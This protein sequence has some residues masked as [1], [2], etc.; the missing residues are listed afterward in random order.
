[1][2][3]INVTIVFADGRALGLTLHHTGPADEA[4]MRDVVARKIR[5]TLAGGQPFG[6]GVPPFAAFVGNG[7]LLRSYRVHPDR[8]Y[9]LELAWVVTR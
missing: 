7:S 9:D 6:L 5:G 2:N 4:L 1:M 3:R 8:G